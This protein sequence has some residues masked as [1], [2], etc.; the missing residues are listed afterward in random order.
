MFWQK[1]KEYE[2]RDE[3]SYEQ[4]CDFRNKR[5]QKMVK[6]CYKNV[7]Y[8]HDLF[9][10]GGINPDR[11]R[12]LED[13]KLLPLLTKETVNKQP[14]KFLSKVV[15]R[16]KLITGHTSGTTGAGFVFQT[17]QEAI[18]EQ[19][20]VWWRYRR[21]LG[22]SF[23]TLSAN[24]GTRFIVPATQ[25]KPPFWR[26][27]TPCSQVYFSAFHE[28]PEFLKYYIEEIEKRKIT[29]LHGYPSLLTELANE[30]IR[31]NNSTLKKQIKFVTIG[32]ENLL[33]YQSA[34]MERA[35]GV[36][37]FQHYGLSEGVSNFS[38]NKDKIIV[39]DEDFAVTE[40]LEKEGFS[41][42]VGTNLTNYAMPLLRWETHDT[43]KVKEIKELGRIVYS[44]DGRIEDYITLPS[45]KK[46][47]KLDHVFKDAVHLSEVQIRQYS[48]YSIKVFYV[49]RDKQAS[50]DIRRARLLF[51]QTFGE[52]V[53]LIFE[54]IK[55][56]HKAK[57]GKLRFIV[58]DIG[59]ISDD[60]KH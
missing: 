20:A 29:W 53:K 43:A 45:G 40:F 28:K 48:D 51:E 26:Y 21:K 8:Y 42:I 38:E 37:V 35:F 36:H 5:L 15:P 11:I 9:N 57:S 23:G 50:E 18:C 52:P 25:N 39:V 17:T 13:L 27:N 54:E 22:I 44:L 24:F 7:P 59:K 55:E 19:W 46:I 34:I 2:D 49:A 58:S 31:E 56:V 30:V 10:N 33:D 60:I 1:L 12:S 6:Y 47:G 14:D 4:K 41:T 32:A 16:E 3:W